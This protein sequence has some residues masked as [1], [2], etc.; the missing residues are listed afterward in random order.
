[1]F[2]VPSWRATHELHK[3]GRAASQLLAD[4]EHDRADHYRRRM[5]SVIGDPAVDRGLDREQFF[6]HQD[7]TFR[8]RI[9]G[10]RK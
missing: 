10:R 6:A 7:L 2:L 3:A 5:A 8:R 1:M 9:T 4:R